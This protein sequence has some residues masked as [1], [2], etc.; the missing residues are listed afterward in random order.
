MRRKPIKCPTCGT[1]VQDSEQQLID[2]GYRTTCVGC[3]SPLQIIG[4]YAYIPA[5]EEQADD[6]H[7]RATTPPPFTD[8]NSTVVPSRLEPD[9]RDPLLHDVVNFIKLC[10]AITPMMLVARF[11]ISPERACDILDTLERDGI[12]GPEVGGAPR[13]ILIPHNT[14]LPNGFL[15]IESDENTTNDN[16]PR[17][18]NINCATGCLPVLLIAMILAMA[19]RTC[20]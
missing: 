13:K 2:N 14:R 20:M 17:V 19:L 12:V 5:D 10:N 3:G 11:G 6:L 18:I 16:P 8:D 9:G 15:P 1:T 4:E 7:T